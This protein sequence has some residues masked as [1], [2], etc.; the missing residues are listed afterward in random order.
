MVAGE[1]EL[2]GPDL[3]QGTRNDAVELRV[4]GAGRVFEYAALTGG[5]GSII[6][7]VIGIFILG[8]FQIFS[9]FGTKSDDSSTV[10]E[11][12][13]KMLVGEAESAGVIEEEERRTFLGYIASEAQR[14]T[15]I[16]D[17][18]FSRAISSGVTFGKAPAGAVQRKP[19]SHSAEY[20]TSRRSRYSAVSFA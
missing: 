2:T 10:T 17:K 7:T 3:E 18:Y 6:G 5:R 9:L 14:L 15:G 13:I 12:E 1:A 4:G 8:V 11:E 16:V 20:S 19:A